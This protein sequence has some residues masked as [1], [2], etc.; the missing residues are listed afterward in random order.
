MR[1]SRVAAIF[2]CNL[3]KDNYLSWLWEGDSAKFM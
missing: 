2:V 3:H 1:T